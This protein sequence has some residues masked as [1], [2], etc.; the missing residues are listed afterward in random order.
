MSVAALEFKNLCYDYT[1]TEVKFRALHNLDLRV[2]QGEFVAILGASGSGKSTLMNLMGL[3]AQP[4]D[5]KM[6]LNGVDI[7]EL[8]DDQLAQ[9]R[10][11]HLGFVFQQFFLLA[12]LT[13]LENVE[14]AFQYTANPSTQSTQ[15]SKLALEKVH[16]TAFEDRHPSHLSGGQKQRVA[17]ARALVLNPTLLLADEPTGALDSKSSANILNLFSEL[18][19]EGKTIIVITHD[20]KVAQCARRIIELK[21]G[22]IVRDEA[23][24]SELTQAQFPKMLA[25][26]QSDEKS[27]LSNQNSLNRVANFF[28]LAATQFVGLIQQLALTPVRSSLT[29]LGL[30]IGVC[31]IVI[32]ITL[33]SELKI[34]FRKF[35]DTQGG[36]N[37]YI[38][39]DW[40]T[41]DRIGASRWRGIHRHNELPQLNMAFAKFGR[42]DAIT[43]EE[44]CQTLSAFGTSSG[45]ISGI[46]TTE[47]FSESA[48]SPQKGRFFTPQELQ[49]LQNE[50][51]AI[52]G[53][54]AAQ[55]LFPNKYAAESKDYPIGEVIKIGGN[56]DLNASVK[57]IGVANELD[58]LFDRSINATIWIPTSTMLNGGLSPYSRELSVVP[59][60]ETEPEWLTESVKNYLRIKT[61]NQFPLRTSVPEQQIGKINVMLGILG[62]LT[63]LVGSLCTI[64]GG[65]GVMNIMLVSITERIREIGIR[66]ALGAKK[67]Q[68]RNQFLSES[69]F[70]CLIG[71]TLGILS[72][73]A[74]SNIAIGVASHFFPKL[75]EDHFLISPVAVFAA[76]FS[77]FVCGIVFGMMP[78]QRAANMDVVESL[79]QE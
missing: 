57:V 31:S 30:A 53:T 62:G 47:Q 24:N 19:A 22:R 39:Y 25:S 55:T 28:K 18:N 3:M 75:V 64:I 77:S 20:P 1:S 29:L 17:I 74:I 34:I 41:A 16:L 73:L 78:S 68:I 44:G 33:T 63:L 36:R 66:R 43:E 58:S 2:E 54:D 72:G 46:N 60:N 23:K 49:D 35:F 6:F 71:G 45:Q 40:R 76:F 27:S 14:L 51:V 56:C 69:V 26:A 52:L 21:D 50:K 7:S 42:I 8:S 37:G 38:K 10:S 13:A 9:A 11:A 61:A 59:N 67:I 48:M 65:V 15:I 4:T 79:R 70:L 32:M 5:G 12:R